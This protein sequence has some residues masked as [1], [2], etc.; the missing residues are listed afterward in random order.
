MPKRL[1][2][3]LNQALEVISYWYG[4]E[5]YNCDLGQRGYLRLGQYV[6]N[7][8]GNDERWWSALVVELNPEVAK[9]MIYDE[10]TREETP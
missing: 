9:Q 3:D 4:R 7:H 6:Y 1:R 2:G 10:Y 8:L 5:P